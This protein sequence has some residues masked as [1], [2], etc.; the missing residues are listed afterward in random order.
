MR[1]PRSGRSRDCLYHQQ[2]AGTR[3]L[4]A[5]LCAADPLYSALVLRCLTGAEASRVS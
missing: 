3:R 2:G 5:R 1:W 4:L